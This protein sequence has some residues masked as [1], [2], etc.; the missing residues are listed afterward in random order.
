MSQR[1]K[2]K[3]VAVIEKSLPCLFM[4]TRLSVIGSDAAFCRI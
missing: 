1:H 4:M 3:R 2:L